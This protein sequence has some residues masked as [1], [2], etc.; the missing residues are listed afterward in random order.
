MLDSPRLPRFQQPTA[1]G[2]EGAIVQHVRNHSCW[3][4]REEPEGGSLEAVRCFRR[5]VVVVSACVEVVTRGEASRA[6]RMEVKR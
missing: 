2:P 1:R 5:V 4:S 3:T 6:S